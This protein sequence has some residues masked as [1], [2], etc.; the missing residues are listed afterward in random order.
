MNQDLHCLGFS[1]LIVVFDIVIVVI[2]I[3]RVNVV[4][5]VAGCCWLLLCAADTPF[6]NLSQ[7]TKE[8]W[9]TWSLFKGF[10]VHLV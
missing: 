10:R 9:S 7:A 5:A 6:S 2:I 3:I 8:L 1:H 4:A